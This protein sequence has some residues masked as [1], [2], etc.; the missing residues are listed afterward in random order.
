MSLNIKELGREHPLWS[1]ETTW[2]SSRSSKAA[3]S[4]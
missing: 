2:W 3:W 4:L 1:S